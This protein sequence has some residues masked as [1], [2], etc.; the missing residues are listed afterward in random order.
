MRYEPVYDGNIQKLITD[1]DKRMEHCSSDK[2]FFSLLEKQMK[3]RIDNLKD[4]TVK[5]IKLHYVLCPRCG[6]ID[7]E[8][9]SDTKGIQR[10]IC[11][12]SRC[13]CKFYTVDGKVKEKIHENVECY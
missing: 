7:G 9:S 5:V 10:Y 11:K 3:L 2:E 6:R 8:I 1:L 12:N 13:R 4:A